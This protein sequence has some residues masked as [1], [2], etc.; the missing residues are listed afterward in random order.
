MDIKLIG[1][2]LSVDDHPHPNVKLALFEEQG[3]FDI[4]LDNPL[5]IR[6]LLVKE[7]QNLSNFAEKLN[8]FALVESSWL[9]N[10]LIIPAMFIRNV[11][12]TAHTLSDM[13]I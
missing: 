8:P 12:V 6:G 13:Q 1:L 10:P 5:R 11:L 4:L 2:V 9:K 3:L 7:L